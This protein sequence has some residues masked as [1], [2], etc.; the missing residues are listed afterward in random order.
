MPLIAQPPPPSAGAVLSRLHAI[1]GEHGYLPEAA[2]RQAARDLVLPLSQLYSAAAFY[3]AFSFQPRGRHTIQ[4]CMG[5]ACYIRG[6]D[7]LLEK[8]EASLSAKTGETTADRIFTLETVHC[9]GSCSMS[10]V[11]RV[12]DH[13]YGRLR[14]DRV[15]RIL[16][17]YRS[18]K[19]PETGRKERET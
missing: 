8:I 5:T 10:P 19:G 18:G 12:D 4:V 11:M 17:K 14:V 16:K 7:R 2:V 6:G 13:T 1:H 9:L 3:S 15:D